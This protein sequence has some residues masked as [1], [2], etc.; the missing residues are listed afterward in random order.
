MSRI[1]LFFSWGPVGNKAR[2]PPPDL[3]GAMIEL[4]ISKFRHLIEK[5]IEVARLIHNKRF[6]TALVPS[7]GKYSCWASLLVDRGGVVT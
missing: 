7:S 3:D 6:T 1:F 2:H 4:D 5:Y